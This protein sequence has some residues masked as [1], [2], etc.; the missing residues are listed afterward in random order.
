MSFC[1]A[2]TSALLLMPPV[3]PRIPDA[4]SPVFENTP[5]ETVWKVLG[6]LYSG[7]LGHRNRP[8]CPT[9]VLA[10]RS[11]DAPEHRPGY[12]PDSLSRQ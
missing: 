1:G 11:S 10:K 6:G 4:G 9:F 7:L 8:L 5:S 12:F 3:Y 2:T